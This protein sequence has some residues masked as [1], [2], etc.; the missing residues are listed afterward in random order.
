MEMTTEQITDRF[1]KIC[2]GQNAGCVVGAGLNIVM[3]ALQQLPKEFVGGAA[4]SLRL[5]A[6]TLD[7][8]ASGDRH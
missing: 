6:D 1:A 3:T 2:G 4:V 7:T 5:M 8:I